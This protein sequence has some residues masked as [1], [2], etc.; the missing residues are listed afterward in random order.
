M[1]WNDELMGIDA[2]GTKGFT[3]HSLGL[4]F[5]GLLA[6]AIHRVDLVTL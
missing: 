6:F 5:C 2:L 4:L 3:C 1:H